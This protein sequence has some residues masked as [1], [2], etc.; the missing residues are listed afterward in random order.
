MN[1]GHSFN[2]IIDDFEWRYIAFQRPSD[3][4][5]PLNMAAPIM[6]KELQSIQLRFSEMMA[7]SLPAGHCFW[8]TNEDPGQVIDVFAFVPENPL[9]G[10]ALNGELWLTAKSVCQ[11]AYTAIESATKIRAIQFVQRGFIN[12]QDICVVANRRFIQREDLGQRVINALTGLNCTRQ[13]LLLRSSCLG[14]FI[15]GLFDRETGDVRKKIES[16][17]RVKIR[18]LYGE[19]PDQLKYYPTFDYY[20]ERRMGDGKNRLCIET[21]H[22]RLKMICDSLKGIRICGGA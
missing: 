15:E 19:N 7:P 4:K 8:S 16:G 13:T 12:A 11:F 20:L 10:V 9:Q 6:S 22:H 5:Q 1:R 3:T 18:P 21:I 14:G 17:A 2:F